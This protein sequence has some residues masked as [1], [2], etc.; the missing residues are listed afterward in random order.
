[1]SIL[2]PL[3]LGFASRIAGSKYKYVGLLM[4]ILPY[5]LIQD[6]IYFGLLSIIW[7]FAWKIT[8]HADG[9]QDY[10][11]KNFLSP[12]VSKFTN[13]LNIDRASHLYDSIFWL[14]KGT[15]I[16]LLPA[17]LS[18]NP[19]ILIASAIAYPLSYHLGF[20]YLGIMK[21]KGEPYTVG[22][23]NIPPRLKLPSKLWLAPTVWGE[24]LGGVISGLGFMI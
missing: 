22:N 5:G 14:T 1:M 16:A 6:N 4:Y 13:K 19:Y 8:G 15:L 3:Y 11:R 7:V 23:L 20:N 18:L 2:Y 17:V 10:Q 21:V 9:F 12:F 24:L